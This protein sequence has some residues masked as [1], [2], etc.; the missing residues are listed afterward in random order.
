[1]E[2]SPRRLTAV[3]STRSVY[4]SKKYS[5]QGQ[6]PFLGRLQRFPQ[7]FQPL[8]TVSENIRDVCHTVCVCAVECCLGTYATL[9]HRAPLCDRG[10]GGG[11]HAGSLCAHEPDD[12]RPLGRDGAYA[13][14]TPLPPSCTHKVKTL[15]C[16]ATRHK[17][18]PPRSRNAANGIA[19]C[20]AAA[21]WA[22]RMSGVRPPT[23]PP[24]PKADAHRLRR[25]FVA[26][27]FALAR[28][29]RATP[30]SHPSPRTLAH[31]FARLQRACAPT[32][33]VRNVPRL[34]S[35]ERTDWERQAPDTRR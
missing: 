30:R 13:R 23:P 28:L 11:S 2:R 31:D 12:Q 15:A 1:M 26:R 24:K 5:T 14:S 18:A 19:V 33:P 7:R 34:H 10:P 6:S 22:S 32:C 27:I 29:A 9:H 17:Y 25:K 35:G 20:G 3:N 16:V 4:S 21:W 8:L